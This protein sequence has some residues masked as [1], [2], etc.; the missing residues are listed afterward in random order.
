M[1]VNRETVNAI[2]K[3]FAAGISP[4]RIA[5][6]LG[7][8]LP[9][10]YKYRNPEMAYS[11]LVKRQNKLSRDSAIVAMYRTGET[12]RNVGSVYGISDE[13]VRQIILKYERR[14]GDKVPRDVASKRAY[15]R[16]R[17]PS[18]IFICPD[19]GKTATQTST[20]AK[21]RRTGRCIHCAA[22]ARS[23]RGLSPA[24]LENIFIRML[25]DEP[26][27]KIARDFGYKATTCSR[28]VLT[29]ARWLKNAGRK[30]D[31]HRLFTGRATHWL[32]RYGIF[33]DESDV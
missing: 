21:S 7:V 31:L 11:A 13:R 15:E 30:D 25:G 2:A 22:A 28:Q 17:H 9:T 4:R 18:I 14:T 33:I 32:R 3:Q 27:V 24:K 8:S 5:A 16:A 6:D 23:A 29:V 10:V 20:Q 12:M 26:R 19:C 1:A